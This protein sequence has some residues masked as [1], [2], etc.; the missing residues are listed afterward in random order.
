[1]PTIVESN[2]AN[3]ELF[4]SAI[5]SRPRLVASLGELK[6]ILADAHEEYAVILG[7]GVDLEASAALADTLRV[8]HPATSVILVRRR[9]DTS[10]L[11][12]A[13][14]SGMREVVEERDLTGL[15]EA[16]KRAAEL[17]SA[18]HGHDE[19]EHEGD[20]GKIVTVFSPKGGVGK[21]TIAVNFA[22]ALAASGEKRVCLVDLDL[23]FGD[24]AITL[25]I[26]P[27]RTLA[28]AAHLQQGLDAETLETLLTPH[29]DNLS[30]LVA[31]VQPDAKD[32]IPAS[33]VG[34]IL[35]LLRSKFDYVVVDTAPAFDE[36]VLQALDETDEMLLVTSLDVPT[37]KNVKIA[38]ETLDLLNFPRDRR[39]LILN[40]ADDKV[41][42]S[43]E[44]VEST[45]GME[46]STSVPSSPQVASATN[47][48]EPIVSS[49][50]RHPASQ[51]LIALAQELTGN[52]AAPR[53]E[54]RHNAV[55]SGRRGLLRRTAGKS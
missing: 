16:V 22:L 4:A 52:V 51:A 21:T 55:P 49:H 42:L 11:A 43:P 36:H 1:M 48:G 13:L 38:L 44:K 47:A 46:I 17:W 54:G 3:A 34:R 25:Q 24:V 27:A 37:L 53:A 33:L 2:N 15:G 30:A 40:R 14:R 9:V 5:G 50:P 31:P 45:L 18:L 35:H 10:V 39:H 6:Q 8:T 19:R 41:G 20:N 12:E 32:A 26:F 7:P 23:G 29:R 28:D